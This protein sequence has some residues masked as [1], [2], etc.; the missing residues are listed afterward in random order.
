MDVDVGP[1]RHPQSKDQ[2]D[3]LVVPVVPV[4]AVI[5]V[6]LVADA[7]EFVRESF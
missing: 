3:V 1:L 6:G 2:T 5:A 7:V 4:G